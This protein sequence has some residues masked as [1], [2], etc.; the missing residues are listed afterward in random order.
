MERMMNQKTKPI[1]SV[2]VT[3]KSALAQK[4]SITMPLT[5]EPAENYSERKPTHNNQ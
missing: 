1:N 4:F 5:Y 3:E 2:G